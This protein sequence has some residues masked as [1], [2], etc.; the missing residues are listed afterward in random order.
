MGL[1]SAHHGVKADVGPRSDAS[2]GLH[3]DGSQG[4]GEISAG[5]VGSLVTL[6]GGGCGDA[7]VVVGG[8]GIGGELR[9]K[10]PGEGG[11]CKACVT[12]V[13]WGFYLEVV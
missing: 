4:G 1:V 6:V 7:A 10:G 5:R 8:K 9:G 13:A 12:Q 11:H 3:C 2:E